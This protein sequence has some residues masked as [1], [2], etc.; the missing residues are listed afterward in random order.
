MVQVVDLRQFVRDPS[1]V[2]VQFS[3]RFMARTDCPSEFRL[4]AAMYSEQAQELNYMSTG[5]PLEAPADYWDEARL[6]S[7]P[8]E[9]ACFALL[10]ISG[11]DRRF[12]NGLYGSKVAECCVRVVVDG[13]TVDE[14][15]M[16]LDTARAGPG[17]VPLPNLRDFHHVVAAFADRMDGADG[18]PVLPHRRRRQRAIRRWLLG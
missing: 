6:L 8:V 15:E 7:N 3:A 18:A 1:Q 17:E 12:W 11:K 5:E 2:I 10:A 4:E 13:S 9:N 16:L 14:G